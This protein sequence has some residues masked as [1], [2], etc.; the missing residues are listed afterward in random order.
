MA[1]A[2]IS[3]IK[4]ILGLQH[5]KTYTD[6]K[7]L[8]YGQL[9]IM[10]DQ[11]HDG[12]HIK[13]LLINFLHAHF[14]SL[15]KAR[16]RGACTC[17]LACRLHGGAHPLHLCSPTQVPNFLVEFITPIIKATKGNQRLVFHTMPECVTRAIFVLSSTILP[18]AHDAYS[19]ARPLRYETW[20]ESHGPAGTKGWQIK[21]YK[22]RI[23]RSQRPCATGVVELT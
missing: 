16:A 14:P 18:A 5:G 11:D 9:M 7:T 20:K 17:A 12:S 10:T 22:A 21:Y 6:A 1:N 19:S 3:H 2:E 15:L 23:L 8:R 13:G 4:Q